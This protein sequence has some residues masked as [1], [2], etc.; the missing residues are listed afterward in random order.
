MP[1]SR[2]TLLKAFKPGKLGPLGEL[3]AGLRA[4]A[5]NE[6]PRKP[7]GLGDGPKFLTSEQ[8]VTGKDRKPSKD[9]HLAKKEPEEEPPRKELYYVLFNKNGKNIRKGPFVLFY[10][11]EQEGGKRVDWNDEIWYYK[12]E[13]EVFGPVS[14]YNMDKLYVAGEVQEDTRVAFKEL[15]KFIKL[16]KIITVVRAEQEKAPQAQ[17]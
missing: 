11:I 12:K 1:F 15:D 16:S 2:E 4:Q 5:F 13:K 6:Q 7:E 14:S 17:E 10:E 8:V 3:P 9:L